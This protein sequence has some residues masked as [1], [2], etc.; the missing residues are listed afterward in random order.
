MLGSDNDT[1]TDTRTPMG[2][3]SRLDGDARVH[4]DV[5]AA[6]RSRKRI[7]QIE[8]DDDDADADVL[9]AAASAD[10]AGLRSS[11]ASD[12]PLDP[13]PSTSSSVTAAAA[14][15]VRTAGARAGP[16][17]KT[18]QAAA[19]SASPPQPASASPAA[20]SA[21]RS[22]MSEPRPAATPGRF[23]GVTL[24]SDSGDDDN[25]N[26]DSDDDDDD[27]VKT[28]PPVRRSGRTPTRSSL[29]AGLD[30]DKPAA[31][32]QRRSVGRPRAGPKPKTAEP[33]DKAG[34][35]VVY[36]RDE[37][38]FVES[39]DFEVVG[40]DTEDFDELEL[41][42]RVLDD[43]CLYD[44]TRG[45]VLVPP[46][47]MQWDG[48]CVMGAG[49]VKAL[50]LGWEDANGD[51]EDDDDDDDE[52]VGDDGDRKNG[53]DGD[54]GERVRVQKDRRQRVELSAV[55]RWQ[56]SYIETGSPLIWLQTQFAYYRL[57]RPSAAYEPI[58][59]EFYHRARVVSMVINTLCVNPAVTL[60]DFVD[61]CNTAGPQPLPS[62]SSDACGRSTSLST[63]G[64][65]LLPFLQP[66]VELRDV[67]MRDLIDDQD[68][69]LE[70]IEGWVDANLDYGAVVFSDL[71]QALQALAYKPVG[72]G[73]KRA[74]QERRE[75]RSGGG[76]AGSNYGVSN[77]INKNTLVLKTRNPT[78]L[79]AGV[80]KVARR[81]FAE[82][83]V[84]V[85]RFVPVLDVA[86]ADGGL[87]DGRAVAAADIA[88]GGKRAVTK[89]G[90]AKRDVIV[91]DAEAMA[92]EQVLGG[93]G[94]SGDVSMPEAETGTATSRPKTK[95]TGVRSTTRTV[96]WEYAPVLK[97]TLMHINSHAVI[98]GVRI[99][100]GDSV[101]VRKETGLR[102][103]KTA[104]A[105]AVWI[106]RVMYMYE[107]RDGDAY[108]HV[109]WY[110]PASRTLLVETAHPAEL[111]LVDE[112]TRVSLW[113][114]AGVA[115]VTRLPRG[116]VEPDEADLDAGTY[117]YRY[118]YDVETAAAEDAGDHEPLPPTPSAG[119][120]G[121]AA[122]V[123]AVTAVDDDTGRV[124][125]FRLQDTD[126]RL[127]D[128]VYV[129]PD[130]ED[131][132][133]AYTIGQILEIRA[134]KASGAS[135]A[136]GKERRATTVKIQLFERRDTIME[137]GGGISLDERH[138]DERRLVLVPVTRTV[139]V[140]W[141]EGRC[142]V[143]HA[144]TITDLSAFKAQPDSFWIDETLERAGTQDTVPLP[145]DAWQYNK[146][147]AEERQRGIE[148]R[149]RVLR[150]TPKIVAMDIFSGCG[151]LTVGMDAT[152]LVET[153][154][155]IEFSSS[156]S[157]T[158]QHN[159]PDA[160]VHCQCANLLLARAVAIQE[161]GETPPVVMDYRGEPLVDLPPKGS[162]NFIYCGPPCQGFSGMN[163]FQKADD[164][165]NTLV[166]SSLSYVEFYKPDY[167]LLENVR[168]LLSYKLGGK[169]DGVG[170]IKGGI[171]M[172]ML[173]FILRTLHSLDYQT[174]FAVLQAGNQGLPQSRRRLIIWGARRGC[175]LPAFPQPT[176]CFSKKGS[177]TV[178][179]P[180]EAGGGVYNPVTRTGGHAPH[181]PVTVWDAISDLPPFEYCNPHFSYKKSRGLHDTPDV[182]PAEGVETY[183]VNRDTT[184]DYVGRMEQPYTHGPRSEYQ[185]MIRGGDDEA[186]LVANHVTR[187]FN[188]EN[189]ER[190]YCVEMRAYAD[191]HSLP[192]FLR[193]WCLTSK[194]S[195]AS[196]NN[197]WKGLFG[198]LDNEGHFS[199]ALTEMQPMGKQGSVIHPTL[200]RVLSVRE[201]ARSQGFP[202]KFVFLADASDVAMDTAVSK[203]TTGTVTI[204]DHRNSSRVRVCDMYRQVG[205]AVPPPLARAIGERLVDALVVR[206]RTG[207]SGQ[208]KG[209]GRAVDVG[210]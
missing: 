100:T 194:D 37:S 173:K 174:R 138:H 196:R 22:A 200:R 111:L 190:I 120:A 131:T 71:Y 129:V 64:S 31:R 36:V 157:R 28:P 201:S 135:G 18:A 81:F 117:F 32:S 107:D 42:C 94:D 151:G 132:V 11:S 180:K 195:A 13:P 203:D 140:A 104:Y 147:A 165:K 137:L 197:G 29:S 153:R 72:K 3:D 187:K 155:A 39:A 206:A 209:K 84:D 148:E 86:G 142:W 44:E 118:W 54:G 102:S 115:D 168:N 185:R 57:G 43:F 123:P 210:M 34:K 169:Q 204:S 134:S 97:T 16:R 30:N 73:S 82:H 108:A 52:S 139:S 9:V 167:F 10:A 192:E 150:T 63:T 130:T 164:I 198:R 74:K 48:T 116:A 26:N 114:I 87:V 46:D 175:P 145:L 1:P 35:D 61:H 7:I 191:H 99:T 126:Y 70:A 105:E 162:I 15:A 91:R 53:D 161:R 80:A 101:Y 127:L 68:D 24:D 59:R 189:V 160:T 69:I 163:R 62:S 193:P 40:E 133:S 109:R 113:S 143:Q 19:R 38:A 208:S 55:F 58:Y 149:Q 5:L 171:E 21:A 202:D 92:S 166:A 98:D 25:N 136:T 141:L 158:F 23:D 75:R 85:S 106:G 60:E 186:P 77:T 124:L 50:P 17:S 96:E 20:S 79:T 33:K 184:H 121:S 125:A 182:E 51:D 122:K 78:V 95:S 176:H 112:C 76:G 8:D 154:H 159:F 172:G 45:N 205:N 181:P 56:P 128:F 179:F 66:Q 93:D 183:H 6:G 152:G 41:P 178:K 156:A 119:L 207:G 90:A 199:T 83:V 89:S 47:A 65:H 27:F 188:D 103:R 12:A 177:L 4:A 14:A 88:D 170:R 67:T 49:L 2:L 144:A 110:I 146:D